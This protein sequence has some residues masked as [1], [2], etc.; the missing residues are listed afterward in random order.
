MKKNISRHLASAVSRSIAYVGIHA[1][2]AMLK[3][4]DPDE[5]NDVGLSAYAQVDDFACGYIAAMSVAHTLQPPPT[6]LQKLVSAHDLWIALKPNEKIGVSQTG[7]VRC[8]RDLG[9]CAGVRRNLTLGAIRS[10]IDEGC[11]VITTVRTA[12]PAEDHWTV[13]H[14][15]SLNPS[16]VYLSNTAIVKGLAQVQPWPDFS[17]RLWSDRGYGIVCRGKG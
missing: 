3:R 6:P 2:P 7:L 11:P 17:R 16:K 13:I 1:L 10:L 8:L 4:P 12:D 14:G 5:G 15:Y 9:I